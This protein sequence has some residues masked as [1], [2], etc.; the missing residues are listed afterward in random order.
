[1]DNTL[2]KLRYPIGKYQKPEM[3]GRDQIEEWIK[4]IAAFPGRLGQETGALSDSEQERRYRPDGWTIRQ[5]VHHCADSHMN[6]FI[7]FKLAMTEETP[8]VKPYHEGLWAQLPDA[9]NLPLLASLR[10]LE[11]LHERWAFLMKSM[12]VQ[13][14]E[15]EFFHPETR[16]KTS[17]K[18]CLSLYAWHCEHHLAH[19]VLA[20]Q[21]G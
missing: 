17:L 5:V 3:I 1:M 21:R 15:K 6:S 10:V 9:A 13:D 14:W 8:T 4:V 2:E 12:D 16:A 19:V 7:R 18:A 11:G 20:R